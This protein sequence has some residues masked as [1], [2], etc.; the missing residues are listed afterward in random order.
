MNKIYQYIGKESYHATIAGKDIFFEQN[1]DLELPNENVYIRSMI[2]ASLLVEV[3]PAPLKTS[4]SKK[5]K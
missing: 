4:K 2:E 5:K 1:K 3:L